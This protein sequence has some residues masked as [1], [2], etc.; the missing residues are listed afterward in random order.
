M[1]L[2]VK[3][4]DGKGSAR[5]AEVTADHALRV[6]MFETPA[7]DIPISVLTQFK[8]FRQYLKN[9]A[10][11]ANC[12]VNA[13]LSVPA[14][15]YI[16]AEPGK[17]L[18]VSGIRIVFNGTLLDITNM[19]ARKFG[20]AAAAPGLPNGILLYAAQG[21][22]QTNFFLEPVKNI[23]NFLS[24]T[25][26]FINLINSVSTGVDLLVF[27]IQFSKPICLP[28]GSVDRFTLQVQDDLSSI[29]LLNI[30]CEGWQE[31]TV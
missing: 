15:F 7:A 20:S 2:G 13:S 10:D 26:D 1:S 24:Y 21:G 8:Q 16:S 4:Q 31:I 11:S 6:A 28:Q 5:Q 29:D 23:A 14:Y 27:G 17:T 18:W 3:I 19:E 9:S 22:I 12:N 30:I 25:S